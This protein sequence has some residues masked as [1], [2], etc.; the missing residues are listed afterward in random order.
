[1]NRIAISLLMVEQGGNPAIIGVLGMLSGYCGT[2]LTPMAANFNMVPAALLELDNKHQ[3][4]MTQ[5]LPALTMLILNT[6]LMYFLA[7]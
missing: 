6:T 3:V 5:C 7:F 4:I 1:M 2:L